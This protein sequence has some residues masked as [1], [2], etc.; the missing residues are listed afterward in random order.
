M[1]LS[2]VAP[3]RI[4][5][6]G[7]ET[8]FVIGNT[9]REVDRNLASK[10]E[11]ALRWLEKVKAGMSIK[12]IA[13]REGLTQDRVAQMLRLAWLDPTIVEATAS[14]RQPERLT[15]DAIFKSPHISLWRE[16]R[17]WADDL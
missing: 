4:R 9:D 14:G 6:R 11:L 7:G 3:G 8:R 12:A 5:R 10:I 15:A 1:S 17:V 2:V 16:Q 13:A